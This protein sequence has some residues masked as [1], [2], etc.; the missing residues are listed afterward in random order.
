M[1]EKDSKTGNKEKVDLLVSGVAALFPELSLR[2]IAS[3]K[4]VK[5][6]GRAFH[7]LWLVSGG[8]LLL[9]ALAQLSVRTKKLYAAS[10]FKKLPVHQNQALA[11]LSLEKRQR[12]FRQLVTPFPK[13]IREGRARFGDHPWSISDTLHYYERLEVGKIASQYRLH[14]TEVYLILVEGI[15]RAWPGAD[16]KPVCATTAPLKPRIRY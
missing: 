8:I 10:Q 13:F 11:H 2:T 5:A 16:G 14:K 4:S 7:W 1:I 15:R 12:I 9:V 3:A 6:L